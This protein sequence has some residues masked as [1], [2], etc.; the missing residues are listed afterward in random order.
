MDVQKSDLN[1]DLK[2]L[3]YKTSKMLRDIEINGK[4]LL[5]RPKLNLSSN[6]KKVRAF[7]FQSMFVNGRQYIC[8][9]SLQL[10]SY[11]RDIVKL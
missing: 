9:L 3:M 7:L 11:T 8:I 2:K 10:A 6:A 5:E 4:V 1:A